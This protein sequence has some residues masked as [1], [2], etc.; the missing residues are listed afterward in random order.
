MLIRNARVV[1]LFLSSQCAWSQDRVGVAA[2]ENYAKL[3]QSFA[4]R[5]ILIDKQNYK[6][7]GT[8][9]G[10][11]RLISMQNEIELVLKDSITGLAEDKKEMVWF[12]N[13]KQQV[14]TK[15]QKI[16]IF[17]GKPNA[18]IQAMTYYK[19]DI[20]VG[21]THGLFRVS[22]DQTRVLN[23]FHSENSR[24][25]SDQINCLFADPEGRLWAGTDAGIVKIKGK[26]WHVY[27]KDHKFTGAV[28]TTEGTWLLAEDKMWLVYREDGHERWQD[29]AVKRGLSKG[30][31]RA[32][33]SDS[34]GRIYVASEILVQ[35]D[36]VSD[37]AVQI[38][39]DYGFVSAQTLSLACDRNDDLWV[40]TA[41]RGLFRIDFL[42]NE[43][44]PFTAIAYEKG[45]IK[46]PGDKTSTI[47]VV[48][49]GGKTPYSYRWSAEGCSGS[50][51]DSLGAGLYSI[52]VT[53]AEGEEYIT[54]VK[55]KEPDPI[56]VELVEKSPVSDVNR[57][58][59][60]ASIEIKGGTPPYKILWDNGRT[61]PTAT[62]L[63]GGKHIVKIADSRFCQTV[64]HVF[65]EQPK[66]IPDLDRK[67]LAVGKSLRI[68]ELYF[69]ADSSDLSSESFAVLEEIFNFLM[70]NKDIIVEIGGH[71]NSLPPDDY[72][73]K[74]STT[75]AENVARYLIEKGV[76][77]NQITY[78]GYGKKVP[79]ASNDTPAG[80]QKNQRVELKI[81]HMGT[82]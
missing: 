21:T 42:D 68:N 18:T 50:R 64:A 66:I 80:R 26:D 40:G 11:Y 60:K 59:G 19:G 69:R 79:I 24:L 75:R 10:L 47:I 16:N 13:R 67:T 36:P 39:E 70:N 54:S 37:K 2:V 4:V 41:D 20:W 32:L 43:E 78:R 81:I 23:H 46:C 27:E 61:T 25:P 45:E 72:C 63:S 82:Q 1:V 71:T 35:F 22:D 30:P 73:N 56:T 53:D 5:N 38:D 76:P 77:Q 52:T 55:I 51:S 31:V 62:G 33:A 15:D 8:D 6:W 17:L 58:D 34:K 65:I 48:A 74:L 9:N 3:D 7:L 49:R 12:G 44:E 28:A 29:A 57:K 14:V